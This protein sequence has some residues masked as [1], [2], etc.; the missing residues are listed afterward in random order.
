MN[1]I[2]SGTHKATIQENGLIDEP[3]KLIDDLFGEVYTGANVRPGRI[4]V[5][6]VEIYEKEKVE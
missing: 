1:L 4:V 2:A 3:Q 5:V 6:T